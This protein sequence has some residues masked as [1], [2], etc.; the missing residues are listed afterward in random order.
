MASDP[1]IAIVHAGPNRPLF[2]A[3]PAR[4]S[5]N[6]GIPVVASGAGLDLAYVLAWDLN[7]PLGCPAFVPI[8]ALAT[9][10]DKRRQARAF[11]AAG[12]AT[13]ETHLLPDYA[14]VVSLIAARP[15]R[16]W[17]LKWPTACASIG[18][19]RLTVDFR[20]TPFWAAPFLVQAFVPQAR[21]EVYRLYG[22]AGEL[23]GWNVRRFPPGTPTSP[24]V[25]LAR[26]ARYEPL[27]A[28][29]EAA[30]AEAAKALTATGTIDSF[31]AVDLLLGADGRWLV[32]EVNS[33]G[34]DNFVLR[35]P[36]LGDVATAIDDRIQIAMHHIARS[37]RMPSGRGDFSK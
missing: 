8:D 1:R 36:A 25:T 13:P 20:P 21:P 19:Q 34:I 9:I 26:G 33:D 27:G 28:P 7:V 22:V 5:T 4:L 10:Q 37:P 31:G 15:E 30:Q 11:A 35:D 23:F 17:L 32:L 29:P 6:L 16:S 14:S 3:F 24:W 12:V 2:G 18:H